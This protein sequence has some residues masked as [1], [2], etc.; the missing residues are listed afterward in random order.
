M[1]TFSGG[2][3]RL[4]IRSRPGARFTYSNTG[5]TL[6]GMIIESVAGERYETW[7]ERE[8][9]RPL[10]MVHSTF[11][12]VTQ[13]GEGGDERMALGHFENGE[14]YAAIPIHVR[15]ASQFT[16]T[17]TDMGRFAQFLMS[18][19]RTFNGPF[20]DPALLRAMGRPHGTEAAEAGLA[21][22]YALGLNLRDRHGVVARCHSGNTV[23][24]R[25][26]LCLFDEERRAFFV[27]VNT[28][29]EIADFDRLDG[30]L[31]RA[32]GVVPIEPPADDAG[33]LDITDWE[34]LYV[35]AP[36]RFASAEWI[37]RLFGYVS[38]QK[39]GEEVS[40]ATLGGKPL[41]LT[42]SGG[43]RW[44]ADGR[45]Q[46]S[47]A[48]LR[49]AEGARILTTGT[50]SFERLSTVQFLLPWVSLV[51]GALGTAWILVA[52]IVRASAWRLPPRHPVFPPLVGLL[53]LV[54]PIPLFATQPFLKLGDVTPASVSLA[55]VTALLPLAALIGLVSHFRER[56]R[57]KLATADA[58][59]IVALLKLCAVLAYE[60]LI[61]LRLFAV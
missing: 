36:N 32:L 61:P 5:Y 27:A 41:R 60:R 13:D 26:M 53:A 23:G 56:S 55:I 35:P 49:S 20:I 24:F 4:K 7:L 12:F 40:L 11:G 37:D 17:V 21:V 38:L 3:A 28:D 34:G 44:R 47:H 48:L 57:G 51:A 6:L 10:N 31:I 18:D 14:A 54:A 9:L 15:P 45:V 43:G 22:G 8:L 33:P 25:A 58:T 52:G 50:R 1:T 29:S 59:A 46:S 19:G 42:P 30:E 2:D 39:N 16:T